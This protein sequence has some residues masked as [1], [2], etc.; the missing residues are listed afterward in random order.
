MFRNKLKLWW[1]KFQSQTIPRKIAIIAGVIFMFGVTANILLLM[2][3][4]KGHYGELP[5]YYSLKNIRNNQASEIYSS[6]KK[7]LGKYYIQERT[8][9]PFDSIPDHLIQALVSTEDARFFE[10]NGIDYRSMMRVLVK[11][12]LLMD[13]TSGG[14]STIT[15]QLAKNLFPR[16]DHGLLTMPVNKLKE[17]IVARRIEKIYS[18][19][20]IL[21][22]Y[23]NTVPFGDNAFGIETASERFFSKNPG[24]L[25]IQE[26]AVLVGMLKG[27]TL[28]SPR[29]NPETSRRR[30]NVVLQQMANAG[31][32][33]TRQLDSLQAS[34]LELRYTSVSH[35]QGNAT[36][37]REYLRREL[38]GWLKNNTKPDGTPYNLYTDG[39]KIH[40]TIDSRLQGFAEESLKTQMK[41]LQK[42]FARHLGNRPPWSRNEQ[43]IWDAVK[44]SERYRV[45]NAQGLSWEQILQN[46]NQ[47]QKV[48]VFTWDGEQ[49]KEMTPLDSIK[50][51]LSYLNAGFV[52]MHPQSGHVLAWVGGI[53]H[54]YFKYDH[55]NM[56][57]KRQI[58]STFKPIVYAA[59]LESG[60]DPCE[61]FSN[62]RRTYEEFENWSPRNADGKYEGYYSMEGA[63]THSVNTISVDL[64][65]QTGVDKAVQLAHQ[66]GIDSKVEKVPSIALGTPSISLME[67]VNAYGVFANGGFRVE[68]KYLLYIEDSNGKVIADFRSDKEATRAISPVTNEIMVHMLRSVVNKGTGAKLR[69]MYNLPNDLAGKTG[70]TQSNAD[71]WF[72]GFTPGLVAGAWVGSDDPRIHFRTL[73]LGQGSST[74]LPIF[75]NFLQKV[76]KEKSFAR[77]V[78]TKFPPMSALVN[79]K[80]ACEEFREEE[81]EPAKF[82]ELIEDIFRRS[83]ERQVR[84]PKRTPQTRQKPEKKRKKFGD[85]IRDIFN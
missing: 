66:M 84:Y 33:D 73:Q 83:E 69:Y 7:I 42:V 13:E 15:Q 27:T 19:E 74:A 50:H 45:L 30:R 3:V 21:A 25:S 62:E 72:I 12:I 81:K 57:T 2:M 8:S 44:R 70:T 14:G 10:H 36:Y 55:V 34:E 51:H 48:K 28:Y 16:Q 40:T 24:K 64:L 22:L 82:V 4:S 68:P 5:D 58:G 46:F 56:N 75:G 54:K 67:M 59:A 79:D 20:D 6:D 60:I 38:A 31:H 29:N 78:R 71:G 76:N 26:A 35:N 18:K 65:M 39:L 49:V 41:E 43:I 52:A 17:M 1:R 77:L 80:L 11:S 9:I 37:F 47:V 23:L 32:L 85:F 53:D 63:L 61:Y